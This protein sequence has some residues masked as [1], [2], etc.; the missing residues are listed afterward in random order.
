MPS[1]NDEPEFKRGKSTILFEL[2][3]EDTWCWT[4]FAG[5]RHLPVGLQIE[6]IDYDEGDA[7]IEA[8]GGMLDH[9][10]YELLDPAEVGPGWWVIEGFNVHYIRGDGW[11]TDDDADF[12]CD[13]IR[14]ARWSDIA[15]FGMMRVPLWARVAMWLGLD[16]SV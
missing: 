14:R 11:M 6:E 7:A 1:N 3:E 15:R 12:Y 8:E 16:P 5:G 9:A 2:I 10:V 13:D 4:H